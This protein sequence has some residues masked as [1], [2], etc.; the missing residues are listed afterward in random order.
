MTI[1]DSCGV[2]A[3]A[4]HV[5]R[6][7]ARLELTTRYRPV[8]IQTLI[9]GDAPPADDAEFFYA[10]DERAERLRKAGMLLVYAVECPVEDR[11]AAVRRAAE[12]FVKRVKL[13]YKPKSILLFSDATTELIPVLREAGFEDA[14]VL[15][16]GK[17]FAELPDLAGPV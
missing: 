14:L 5:R 8:H 9:V 7:I 10:S 11:T 16:G 15:A 6:R 1:C 2:M 3:D 4:A 12:T 17:P 13:S